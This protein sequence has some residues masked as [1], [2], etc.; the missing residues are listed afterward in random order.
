MNVREAR[1]TV[2]VRVNSA[3][4]DMELIYVVVQKDTRW[5]SNCVDVKTL[6]SANDFP[7]LSVPRIPTAKI[8][9]AL[10]A[11]NARKALRWMLLVGDAKMLTSA[12][13]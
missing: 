2:M 9:R 8:L 12:C 7:A 6:M 3:S 4:T 10:F 11:V 13:Q 5:T 1:M